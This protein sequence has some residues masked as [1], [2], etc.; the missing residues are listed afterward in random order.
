MGMTMVSFH[1][2]SNFYVDNATHCDL[3]G[4]EAVLQT[5]GA[6]TSNGIWTKI[7]EG[8]YKFV[9]QNIKDNDE[10]DPHCCNAMPKALPGSR[11]K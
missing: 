10:H 3:A 8:Y 7:K 4:I 1:K 5:H 6:D 2:I 9:D 11:K